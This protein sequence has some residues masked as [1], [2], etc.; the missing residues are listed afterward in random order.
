MQP[1]WG[2]GSPRYVAWPDVYRPRQQTVFAQQ[3]QTA[4]AAAF[5]AASP[6]LVMIRARRGRRRA[7]GAWL[8]RKLEACCRWPDRREPG[9]EFFLQ[10]EALLGWPRYLSVVVGG[11]P[12]Q[13]SFVQG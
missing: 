12:D 1:A 8:S 10:F 9:P 4:L 3:S 7:R 2:K 5:S 11:L 6:W 13:F